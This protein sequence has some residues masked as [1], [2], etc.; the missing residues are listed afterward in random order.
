MTNF[1]KL[2]NA[3]I[4][5]EKKYSCSCQWGKK[6]QLSWIL[7]EIWKFGF[8]FI[9][10]CFIKPFFISQAH[11]QRNFYFLISG[12]SKRE[13]WEQQTARDCKFN[14]H[15]KNS[16]N[17]LVMNI[18]KLNFLNGQNVHMWHFI[19]VN[20]KRGLFF[21]VVPTSISWT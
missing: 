18:T 13:N 6:K 17:L 21:V 14:I 4:K 19:K 7:L 11:S 9:T 10:G 1:S 20:H 8:C 12:I 2:S 5:K 3:L 15:F 16:F